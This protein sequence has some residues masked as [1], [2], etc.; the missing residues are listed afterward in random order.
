MTISAY[1]D[2]FQLSRNIYVNYLLITNSIYLIIS[3]CYSDCMATVTLHQVALEAGT[4]TA[5]VSRVLNNDPTVNA[6]NKNNVLKAIKNLGYQRQR[7]PAASIRDRSIAVMVPNIE[8]PFMAL[9]LKGILFNT[10]HQGYK[11][12]LFDSA[13]D[14]V[15]DQINLQ[16]VS[17]SNLAGLIYIP[18]LSQ[19]NLNPLLESINRPVVLLDRQTKSNAASSVTADNFL[20][21]YQV[22]KYLI[23]LGHEKILFLGGPKLLSTQQQRLAGFLKALSD[24]GISTQGCPIIDGNFNY[25]GS[26]EAI[27]KLLP[28]Q[29]DISAIFSADDLMAFGARQALE[30]AGVNIPK[31]I[32]ITGF[33]DII[34]S[35]MIGLTTVNFPVIEMGETATRMVI[36]HIEGRFSSPQHIILRP[37]LVIRSSCRSLYTERN[38]NPQV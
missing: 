37:N 38:K 32:S 33:N 27:K 23:D 15:I 11:A 20:G 6:V 2:Y 31:D 25:Q 10:R 29:S 36:D 22:T 30:E 4:S 5:T 7:R 14:L 26:Y 28:L 21:A 8:D 24:N 34:P 16:E 18:T 1:N 12:C 13:N 3:L 17:D 9:I 35:A 19:T